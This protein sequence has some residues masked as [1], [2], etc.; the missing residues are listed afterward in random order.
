M[1]GVLT[2]WTVCTRLTE[3]LTVCTMVDGVDGVY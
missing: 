2:E 1:D 3:R